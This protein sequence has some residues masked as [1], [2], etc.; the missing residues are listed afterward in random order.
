M[1]QTLN[2]FQVF[3][4]LVLVVLIARVLAA[5]RRRS[6]GRGPTIL[7]TSLFTAAS[8][9]ILYPDLTIV[10]ANFLGIQRGADLVLYLSVLG[11]FFGFFLVYTRLR[12]LESHIT[13]IT[14]EL[15]LRSVDSAAAL[16]DAPGGGR[17]DQ[18]AAAGSLPPSVRKPLVP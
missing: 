8:I 17:T 18:R 11:M 16:D 9:A 15:A 14:R 7:W 13:S 4:L 3:S 1:G 12:R 5:H 10:V 6:V 2:Y